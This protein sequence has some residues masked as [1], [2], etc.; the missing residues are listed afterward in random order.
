M[1]EYIFYVEHTLEAKNEREARKALQRHLDTEVHRLREES[2]WLLEQ[3]PDYDS[4]ESGGKI[5]GFL[6]TDFGGIVVRS[7]AKIFPE[8]GRIQSESVNIEGLDNTLEREW[9]EP[10]AGYI[11]DHGEEIEVCM[12]CH[13]FILKKVTKDIDE[14]NLEG[15][16]ECSNSECIEANN[17]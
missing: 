3:D 8:S 17:A 10:Y 14:T 13:E 12:F 5:Y 1:A 16:F 4:N 2:N 6:C 11:E 7:K 15:E 9:F